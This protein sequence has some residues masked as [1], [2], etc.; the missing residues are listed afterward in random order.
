M[1]TAARDHVVK[2]LARAL[3]LPEIGLGEL[4]YRQA[5]RSFVVGQAHGEERGVMGIGKTRNRLAP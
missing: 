5:E 1:E 4:R 2:A 3:G